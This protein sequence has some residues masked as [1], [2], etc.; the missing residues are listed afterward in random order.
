MCHFMMETF[1]ISLYSIS[2]HKLECN[3]EN[4]SNYKKLRSKR[5][6]TLHYYQITLEIKNN[7]GKREIYSL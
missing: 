7:V 6:Q 3:T 4:E 1:Q 2:C 5:Y